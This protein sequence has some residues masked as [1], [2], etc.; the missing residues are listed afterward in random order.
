MHES[1]KA[2]LYLP[3]R[4]FE[5]RQFSKDLASLGP[6]VRAR[7]EAKLSDYVYPIPRQNPCFGPN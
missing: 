3:F 2:G 6:A 4:S 5:T 7:L 1:A